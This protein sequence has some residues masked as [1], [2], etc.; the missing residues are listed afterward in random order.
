MER[1]DKTITIKLDLFGG[2]GSV[3]PKGTKESL[4]IEVVNEAAAYKF[5]NSATTRA[6]AKRQT[7]DGVESVYSQ[8]LQKCLCKYPGMTQKEIA[9]HISKR[10]TELSKKEIKK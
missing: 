7:K 4:L 6:F 8:R 5:V 3:I 9:E 10:L 1:A 2:E